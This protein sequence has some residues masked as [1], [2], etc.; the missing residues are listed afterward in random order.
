[1]NIVKVSG[2]ISPNDHTLLRLDNIK[3]MYKHHR[4]S[5]AN[6]G[7]PAFSQ[8]VYEKEII[9]GLCNSASFTRTSTEYQ[10]HNDAEKI[11]R[12]EKFAFMPSSVGSSVVL[13][14]YK[15]RSEAFGTEW[16]YNAISM[17]R[18][19]TTAFC[20]LLN[21]VMNIKHHDVAIALTRTLWKE[22]PTIKEEPVIAATHKIFDEELTEF[23]LAFK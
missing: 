21:D 2:A 16:H 23:G 4:Q 1:M 15:R 13:R 22:Y 9:L 20:V 6:L 18:A 17:D 10:D 14:T 5:C 19:D 11:F 8:F 12:I 3:D 7:V